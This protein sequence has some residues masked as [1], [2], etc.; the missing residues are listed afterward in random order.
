MDGSNWSML[1]VDDPIQFGLSI[2]AVLILEIVF[3]FFVT[4]KYKGG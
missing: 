4:M 1:M 2:I 3:L